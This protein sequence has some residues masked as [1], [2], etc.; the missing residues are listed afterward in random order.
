VRSDDDDFN[1]TTCFLNGKMWAL[2]LLLKYQS[3]SFLSLHQYNV[4]GE[5]GQYGKQ[6]EMN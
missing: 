2:G 5:L 4:L 1:S 3:F 6:K